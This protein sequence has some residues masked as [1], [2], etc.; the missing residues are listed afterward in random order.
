MDTTIKLQATIDA[1]ERQING[2]AEMLAELNE[3]MNDVIKFALRAFNM[4]RLL[5]RIAHWWMKIS[6]FRQN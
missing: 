3:K 4:N 5:L 2:M 1:R 6:N